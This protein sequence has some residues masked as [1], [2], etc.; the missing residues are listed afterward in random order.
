MRVRVER[1]LIMLGREVYIEYLHLGQWV[2]FC[3]LSQ[4]ASQSIGHDR[5]QGWL[6]CQSN[7]SRGSQ[8]EKEKRQAQHLGPV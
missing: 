2:F 4:V 6:S 5:M 8:D 1:V 3:I 7:H